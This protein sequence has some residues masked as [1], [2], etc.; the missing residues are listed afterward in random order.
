VVLRALNKAVYVIEVIVACALVLMTVL[1][2]I[3]LGYELF[4]VI[5]GQHIL[6]S[7]DFIR[8]I[9][10]I[11]EI[12]ILIELFRIAVAYMTHQNVLPTVFE[13]ALIAV[14]RKFVVFE[15]AN[16]TLQSALALAVLLL[17][18][19][20]SWWLLARIDACEYGPMDRL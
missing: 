16:Q 4:N 8:L 10:T 9:S 15:I 12:F 5:T 17:A 6:L 19:A 2:V 13:A 11:L 3:A 18:V 14:A 1:A 7:A 20:V